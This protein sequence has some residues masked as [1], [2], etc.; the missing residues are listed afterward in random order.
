MFLLISYKNVE[1]KKKK[2]RRERSKEGRWWHKGIY[3]VIL[4]CRVWSVVYIHMYKVKR[5]GLVNDKIMQ[6][7]FKI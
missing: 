1:E 2:K 5:D 4:Q 6:T 3:P 7:N